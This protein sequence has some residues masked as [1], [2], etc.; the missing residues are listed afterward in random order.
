MLWTYAHAHALALI[1]KH[2]DVVSVIS[3]WRMLIVSCVGISKR[4][5]ST[6]LYVVNSG[7]SEIIQMDNSFNVMRVISGRS[8]FSNNLS[9]VA[10]CGSHI[11]VADAGACQILML[12]EDGTLVKRVGKPGAGNLE[13]KRPNGICVDSR[14]R[15]IVSDSLN[16]RIKVCL[17]YGR[18]G[19]MYTISC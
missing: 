17:F 1:V 12:N 10:S 8:L 15:V 18:L 2:F 11:Y 19:M 3:Y 5:M 14:G 7:R 9:D 4:Q 16:H 13:F 6:S